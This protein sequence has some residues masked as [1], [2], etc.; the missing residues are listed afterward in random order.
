MLSLTTLKLAKIGWIAREGPSSEIP[1][2]SFC[3]DFYVGVL[4][5]KIHRHKKT[6]GFWLSTL[7]FWSCADPQNWKQ[8]SLCRM[9]KDTCKAA[10]RLW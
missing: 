1:C 9:W 3:T 5:T 8:I 7:A 4:K 2:C 10:E 6:S